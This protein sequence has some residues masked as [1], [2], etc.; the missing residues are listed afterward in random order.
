MTDLRCRTNIPILTKVFY[1]TEDRI[2]RKGK[3]FKRQHG[4]GYL[5]MSSKV[6]HR[7]TTSDNERIRSTI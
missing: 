6:L 1:F 2:W 7:T 3:I 4:S 5:V